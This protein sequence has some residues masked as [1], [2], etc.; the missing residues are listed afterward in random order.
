MPSEEEEKKYRQNVEYKQKRWVYWKNVNG[1]SLLNYLLKRQLKAMKWFYFIVVSIISHA[2]IFG[3][4]K[5]IF[6]S[7]L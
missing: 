2:F 1:I 6:F 4:N 5:N 7:L 3:I